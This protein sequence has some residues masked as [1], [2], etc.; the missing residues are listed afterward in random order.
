MTS[1]VDALNKSGYCLVPRPTTLLTSTPTL[2]VLLG[3]N[4]NLTCDV[5]LDP[6][7][8]GPVTVVTTWFGPGVTSQNAP[9]MIG[10]TEYLSTLVLTELG[11]QGSGNYTCS[12]VVTAPPYVVPLT[13]NTS[14]IGN[15]YL[16]LMMTSSWLHPPVSIHV[17]SITSPNTPL[18]AGQSYTLYCNGTVL[19]NLSLIPMVTWYNSNGVV[20]NGNDITVSNGNLTF[21]FLH[22]SH[23]GQYTC[24]TSLTSPVI[25]TITQL[26]NITVLSMYLALLVPFI[27]NTFLFHSPSSHCHHIHHYLILCWYTSQPHMHCSAHPTSGHS[28]YL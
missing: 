18:V 27:N 19:G 6:S 15:D 3:A 10:P 16:M 13:L 14:I 1:L 24:Q 2:P 5:L 8:D 11:A 25:S 7:V 20:T 28:C 21:N 12:V 4:V 23:G 17:V 26:M 9:Q 22:T